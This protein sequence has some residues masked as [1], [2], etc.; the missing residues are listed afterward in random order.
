MRSLLMCIASLTVLIV[1]AGLASQ[2]AGASSD[3]NVPTIEK[4]MEV[5]HKGKNSPLGTVKAALKSSSP[6]WSK[7][8]D[9]T[10]LFATY[11]PALP[12]NDPPRGEK[13]DF[14]KLAKAYASNAKALDEAARKED[15]KGA[16]AALKKISGSCA[17]CH[18]AHREP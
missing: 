3:E 2:R 7:V 14:V 11:A 16:R 17:G 9:A 5:L 15:L 4:V 1:A 8:K 18:M 12:K 13:A 6:D 10:K